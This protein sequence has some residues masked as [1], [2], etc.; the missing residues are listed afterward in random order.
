[1][2][3]LAEILDD[4]RSFDPRE[5]EWLE[6]DALIQEI[7]GLPPDRA[8]LEPLLGVFLRFPRHDGHEVLWGIVHAV[9]AIPGY[10]RDVVA[11]MARTPT[12]FLVTLGWRMLNAGV[13]TVDGQDVEALV[14][15]A[16]ALAPPIDGTL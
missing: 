12:D 14:K 9:E 1:M 6:L 2:R 3:S 5:Q 15:R 13:R 11:L 10:E 7:G 8:A 16:E 4:V